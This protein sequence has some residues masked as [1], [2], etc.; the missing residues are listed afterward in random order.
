MAAAARGGR[1]GAALSALASSHSRANTS[2]LRARLPP[3]FLPG[4]AA[5]QLGRP[6]AGLAPGRKGL[7]GQAAQQLGRR[8]A[9]QQ[10]AQQV[11]V[12]RRRQQQGGAAQDQA[13][14]LHRPGR[15]GGQGPRPLPQGGGAAAAGQQADPQ[16]L[17][18]Q[19]KGGGGLLV[20]DGG[21]GGGGFPMV[22]QYPTPLIN[23]M[24]FHI[25]KISAIIVPASERPVK[26]RQNPSINR[27]KSIK[28]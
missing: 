10:Q 25:T 15:Q 23:K 17:P 5:H 11:A 27:H 8:R 12:P 4:Q 20:P 6:G 1:G 18:R 28:H 21:Q 2:W 3:G 24:L 7:L 19:G 13:A 26:G 16:P 14:G 22:K 9:G